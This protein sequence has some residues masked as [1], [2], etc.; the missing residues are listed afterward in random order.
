MGQ[1]LERQPIR[2]TVDDRYCYNA[3][4]RTE[5]MYD[6]QPILEANGEPNRMDCFFLKW[7]S[8]LTWQW[9]YRSI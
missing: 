4:A 7:V 6:Q 8:L 9:E 5:Q 3:I 2:C 1:R